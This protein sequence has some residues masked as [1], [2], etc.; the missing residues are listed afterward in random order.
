[1]TIRTVRPAVLNRF[2][3]NWQSNPESEEGDYQGP[4]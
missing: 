1:M 2:D 4:V 3:S